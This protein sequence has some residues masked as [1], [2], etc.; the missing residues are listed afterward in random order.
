MLNVL[1]YLPTLANVHY[2]R[3]EAQALGELLKYVISGQIVINWYQ[4]KHFLR[5]LKYYR[6]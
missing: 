3:L 4:S 1:V 2:D 6:N 5:L